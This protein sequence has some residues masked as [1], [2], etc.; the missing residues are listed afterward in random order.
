MIEELIKTLGFKGYIVRKAKWK[1]VRTCYYCKMCFIEGF[2][3]IIRIS[4]DTELIF[5][6]CSKEHAIRTV[7]SVLGKEFANRLSN[8]TYSDPKYASFLKFVKIISKRNY[9]YMSCDEPIHIHVFPESNKPEII[10]FNGYPSKLRIWI[11]YIELR[12][13]DFIISL[14]DEI[15]INF[16]DVDKELDLDLRHTPYYEIDDAV[17]MIRDIY[18]RYIDYGF[19][20]IVPIRCYDI[21]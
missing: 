5:E 16:L 18:C 15:A 20:T 11:D 6:S 3:V 13:K 19:K 4:D 2:R 7:K 9:E 12:H 8:P 14:L 21:L 10:I 17:K 1:S